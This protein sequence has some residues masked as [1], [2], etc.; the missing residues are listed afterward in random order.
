MAEVQRCPGARGEVYY[1]PNRPVEPLPEQGF[2]QPRTVRPQI[3]RTSRLRLSPTDAEWPASPN[4]SKVPKLSR[5][6]RNFQR[7]KSNA[8]ALKTG[9]ENIKKFVCKDGLE[10]PLLNY[11]PRINLAANT[12]A[13]LGIPCTPSIPSSVRSSVVG[14]PSEWSS[15]E[16]SSHNP[17]VMPPRIDPEEWRSGTATPQP[18]A[19]PDFYGLVENDKPVASGNGVSV[20]IHLAEPIL[21]LQGFD[22]T[23]EERNTTMLR[24]S[25]HLRVTKSA[26]IKTIYLKFRGRAETDWPEGLSFLVRRKVRIPVADASKVFRPN[27][28]NTNARRA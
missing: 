7:K 2:F 5:L 13:A 15:S 18:T 22:P 28:Q 4:D 11:E 26:K 17:G 25:L 8:K 9:K 3:L 14:T 24:G 16:G 12:C 27:G 20:S 23:D 1:S 21:F 19:R 6:R 10:K